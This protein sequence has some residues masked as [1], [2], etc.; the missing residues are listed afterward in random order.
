M[1]R[2]IGDADSQISEHGELS[3]ARQIN[4]LKC[5]VGNAMNIQRSQVATKALA[6]IRKSIP[7]VD[8]DCQR[9]KARTAKDRF[10][11]RFWS[12]VERVRVVALEGESPSRVH[13]GKEIHH[14]EG[15]N[16]P[17]QRQMTQT[18]GKRSGPRPRFIEAE[19][20]EAAELQAVETLAAL[21]WPQYLHQII[22][23]DE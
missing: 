3:K 16:V 15:T 21:E 17:V 19:I 13:S 4:R 10:L 11:D 2:G 6:E 7:L 22:G 9:C 18:D 12:V 23:H 14:V 5:V 8:Y 20:V 1:G